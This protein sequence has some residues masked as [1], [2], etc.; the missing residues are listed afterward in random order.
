MKNFYNIPNFDTMDGCMNAI[1]STPIVR[2]DNVLEK[3]LFI[4]FRLVTDTSRP[5]ISGLQLE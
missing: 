5:L 2:G 4:H 3:Q 1:G